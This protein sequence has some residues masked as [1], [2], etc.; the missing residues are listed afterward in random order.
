[1][2]LDEKFISRK[3]FKPGSA[4]NIWLSW[5]QLA[6]RGQARL[7]VAEGLAAWAPHTWLLSCSPA[8]AAPRAPRPGLTWGARPWARRSGSRGHRPR[9]AERCPSPSLWWRAAG[10]A[11]HF[12]APACTTLHWHFTGL[13]T[14]LHCPAMAGRPLEG[15]HHWRRSVS[16]VYTL[17]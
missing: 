2:S 7:L 6:S 17:E 8:L 14:A 5:E 13:V 12:P 3:L 15:N 9:R 16:S 11:P 4:G 1:M 10:T